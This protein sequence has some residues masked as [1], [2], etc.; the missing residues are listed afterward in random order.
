MARNMPLPKVE[1]KGDAPYVMASAYP[2]GPVCVATEGRVKPTDQWFEP[3]AKVT[4][5][6]EDPAQPIGIFGHYDA[7]LIAF[8]QALPGGVTVWAQDL[9]AE[10]AR[11]ITAMVTIGN[12]TLTIPGALIDELGTSAGDKGDISVPGMVLQ[13]RDATVGAITALPKE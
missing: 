8:A 10:R 4:I 5:Q 13:L 1:V 2:N 9:L 12:N 7:L 11:D 6:V 3:R